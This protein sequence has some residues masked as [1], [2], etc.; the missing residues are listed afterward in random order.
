MEA[1]GIEYLILSTAWSELAVPWIVLFS[2]VSTPKMLR[3][4]VAEF[5]MLTVVSVTDA[6]VSSEWVIEFPN[7]FIAPEIVPALTK[8]ESEIPNV[9]GVDR[10]ILASLKETLT[11]LES[12]TLRCWPP[13]KLT[14]MAL[15]VT[16]DIPSTLNVL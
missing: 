7:T 4:Y 13:P 5:S 10:T 12:D 11:L 16:A 14:V 2:I 8:S 6:E 9:D 15:H 3:T 1:M